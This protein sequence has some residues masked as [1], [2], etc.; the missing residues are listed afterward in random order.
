[1]DR[2]AN[3]INGEYVA[4]ASGAY[5]DNYEPATGAVY[6]LTPDS[7]AAD[8]EAAWQAANAAFPG[9]SKT[10]AE[11]R[12]RLLNRVADLLESR[13][14]ELAAA[15]SRDQGKPVSLA[16]SV[17][18]PR[19]VKNFRFFASAILHHEERATD[20]DGTGMNYS[21]RSPLGVCGLISPWNLPLYLLTWKI[22]PAIAVGNTC[23]AKPSELTPMT[24]HLLG[25][26]LNEAGIPRG[27]VN[28]VHGYGQKVGRALTAH[29][30][31]P[32]ISFTGGTVTG[33][34]IVQQSA[35][36]FKK[37]GLELGGKNPNI[38]F[39][40]ADL[41]EAV[42]NSVRS[43]FANQGE[44]CLCGS[45]L[46]VQESIFD[47]FLA[48]FLEETK[49]WTP[50]D[51]A[52]PDTKFGALVSEGHMNKVLSY[53][54]LARQEGGRI[55]C[56]GAR[57]ALGGRVK[58]G[59]FVEPTV[60]TGVTPSCRVM[61][62]EVFGP[63]VTITPFKNEADVIAQAN[64]IQYGLSASLWTTNMSRGHRVAQAL[65]SGIVWVNTWMLRDIRTPFG[66]MKASGLGREGGE[67]SIDFYTEQKNI[68]IKF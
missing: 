66:G 51:P 46:F 59:Y 23:I 9:W 52:D 56:G 61:Q 57:P 41:T 42:P 16:R 3:F 8:V 18:I 53:I 1:M 43:S 62:E 13:I 22:A 6:S 26:I 54:E 44:I 2:L 28:I 60:V 7:D 55:E 17:D 49:T 31:I 58:N 21:T 5:M 50:G 29:P 25:A 12:S 14:D 10:P 39:E 15:E 38:V 64:G 30:K 34:D 68:C 32:L 24:A 63:F 11:E 40:D 4:P 45:R 48:A 20:I 65:H 36:H 33:V 35:P 27:V 67:H 47:T 19:A 37:V